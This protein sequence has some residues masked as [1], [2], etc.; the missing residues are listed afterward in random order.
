MGVMI[1]EEA[2]LRR[3]LQEQEFFPV[4]QP[5]VELR[6]GQ[7]VGFEILARWRHR[8]LG[9]ISPDDFIPALERSLLTDELTHLLLQQAF[10]APVL[11]GSELTLA[12]NVSPLQLLG[13]NVAQPLAEVAAA[14]GFSLARLIIEVT[15]SALLDD[16]P[17]AQ[18]AAR[19]LQALGCRLALDDFGT[20]YSSLRHLHAFPFNEL[21]VDRSFVGTM[22][23][24]RRSRKTVAAVVGLGES[25][26]LTT[27]AE[28]IETQEQANMLLWLGCDQGQGWLY[29]KPV[30]AAELE[31]VMAETGARPASAIPLVLQEDS[32]LNQ[33]AH[34]G[35]RLAQ[36]QAIYDGAPVGLCLLDRKLRYVSLN[37]RLAEINGVPLLEH[38]GRT[39]P[40]VIPHVFPRVEGFIRRAL[41]GESIHGVEIF[42]GAESGSD[43]QTLML[44]YQPVFDEAGEVIGVSVAV[45]DMTGHKRTEEALRESENHYRHMIRLN[46]HVPWVLN[47]RGEVIDAGPR[48]E[49]FTGQPLEEA[50][51]SGWLK[52]LHPDDVQP[53]LEAIRT[54]LAA[55]EPID[56]EYRVHRRG[57]GWR[58]M[59]SRGAPRFSE[60]GEVLCVYGLVEEVHPHKQ[61]SEELVIC[62]SQLRAAIDT[63][64][65]GMLVADAHDCT[66]FMINPVAREI[67]GAAVFAG[68]KLSEHTRL[69]ITTPEQRPLAPEEFPLFRSLMNS[70]AVEAEHLCY[71]RADGARIDLSVT[72]RPIVGEDG[73]L[74]GCV[75]MLRRMG[76]A[77]S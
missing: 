53:T 23:E 7:L 6:T 66:I 15:E 33:H 22:T 12:V 10:A 67:F 25:L 41:S 44:T 75:Q 49:D 30:A 59:R 2:D 11:K 35:Q 43:E 24:D 50:F 56:V 8:R 60:G 77:A 55:G 64:P 34:P 16:L 47:G 73:R 3:A 5:I 4:F 14:S 69:P 46:P 76:D 29:G 21:K 45:T 13:S 70:E 65:I 27:V 17:Q 26:G 20:G 74:I 32:L 37:Q 68:Q 52:M 39:V 42:K 19:D 54:T 63:C 36:L 9:L 28:G 71:R 31:Q 51:G 18:A 72:S 58:W 38:L 1:F 57:D 48:W 61:V 62:Q 40:E